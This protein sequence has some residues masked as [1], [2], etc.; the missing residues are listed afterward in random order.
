MALKRSIRESTDPTAKRFGQVQEAL[1]YEDECI[2]VL[3]DLSL[4]KKK[5]DNA[6]SSTGSHSPRGRQ[7]PHPPQ[8]EKAAAPVR[9]SVFDKVWS[10]WRIEIPCTAPGSP[11]QPREQSP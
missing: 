4:E 2:T 8:T 9:I 6:I 7:P 10:T 3:P 5:F 11:L 1:G